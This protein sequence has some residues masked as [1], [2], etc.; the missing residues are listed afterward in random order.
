MKK[1]IMMHWTKNKTKAHKKNYDFWNKNKRVQTKT[2]IYEIKCKMYIQQWL[3]AACWLIIGLF[4]LFSTNAQEMSDS[5]QKAQIF[6]KSN[7]YG[8]FIKIWDFYQFISR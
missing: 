1:L 4:P 2:K 8:E 7:T 3:E 5:F 6:W